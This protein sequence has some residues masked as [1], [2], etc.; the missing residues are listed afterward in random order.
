M[1]KMSK[2]LLASIM[3][4]SML[5]ALV[6]AVAMAQG[7]GTVGLETKLDNDIV[8]YTNDGT[9]MTGITPLT[10]S[11]GGG[12]RV[13]YR[14]DFVNKAGLPEANYVNSQIMFYNGDIKTKSKGFWIDLDDVLKTYGPGAYTFSFRINA[15]GSPG[16]IEAVLNTAEDQSALGDIIWGSHDKTASSPYVN[17]GGHIICSR[18]D[19]TASLNNKTFTSTTYIPEGS[20]N[21]RLFIGGTMYDSSTR[22]D[23]IKN[24]NVSGNE[25]YKRVFVDDIKITKKA[26]SYQDD[27]LVGK[28][29]KLKSTVTP[30]QG[31]TPTGRLIAVMYDADT[32]EML[33]VEISDE[34]TITAPTVVESTLSYPGE[35]VAD[36]KIKTFFFDGFEN[37]TAYSISSNPHDSL[38]PNTSFESPFTNDYRWIESNANITNNTDVAYTGA[39][40]ASK[41]IA[42]SGTYIKIGEG[43]T[44]SPSS[45]A[46][47]TAL[48]QMLLENGKGTYKFS[49]MAKT[50]DGNANLVLHFRPYYQDYSVADAAVGAKDVSTTRWSVGPQV[51]TPEWQKFEYEVTF[52][53]LASGETVTAGAT[54]G[55]LSYRKNNYGFYLVASSLVNATDVIY[56]DDFKVEKVN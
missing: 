12:A 4:V 36:Y 48:A 24:A 46:A 30:L 13:G 43:A 7:I 9:S 35:E 38:F 17:L 47:P 51:A 55:W 15:A 25:F 56:I 50:K 49:F 16:L 3:A 21:L 53:P 10:H 29:I 26:N 2:K 44:V 45:T 19:H 31:L 20:A 23:S 11:A 22:T 14:E 32:N 8:V 41:G 28:D 27:A 34:M 39:R 52:N 37:L 33:D 1:K 5:V 54:T 42:S 18:W 6:P 40:S